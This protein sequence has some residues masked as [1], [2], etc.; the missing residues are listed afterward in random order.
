MAMALHKSCMLM[1]HFQWAVPSRGL[2]VTKILKWQVHQ[3]GVSSYADDNLAHSS[4]SNDTVG[5][6]AFWRAFTQ[7]SAPAFPPR[8][9]FTLC[10]DDSCKA[11]SSLLI[12]SHIDAVNT[13]MSL[14][15]STFATCHQEHLN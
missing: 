5:R 12:V 2:S 4:T 10:S 7:P 8:V 3:M 15:Q 9:I 14:W 6:K 1:P 11:T 13:T